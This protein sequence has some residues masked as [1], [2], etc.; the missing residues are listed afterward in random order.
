M[1]IFTIM[2][3]LC[4]T[5]IS[6]LCFQSVTAQFIRPSYDSL[7]INNVKAGINAE[8]S[9]F[10]D[11]I[12]NHKFEVPKGSGKSTIFAANLW[13]GA[14][15]ATGHQH[16]AAQ[17]YKQ[18]GTDYGSGPVSNSQV[19]DSTY[20]AQWNKL[21]KI[22]KAEVDAHIQNWSNWNYLMPASIVNYPAN[23]D[24]SKGQAAKLAPYQD[25]NQNNI[26]DPEN[27]DYPLIKGDQALLFLFN[28]DIYPHSETNS[29]WTPIK[30]EIL[31]MMYGFNAPNDSVLNN[32]VFLSYR[33]SNRS[34]KN[35]TDFKAGFWVDFSLG[36]GCYDDQVGSDSTNSYFYAYDE[37]GSLAY[38]NNAPVQSIVFL[39]H[40][41]NS[42]IAYNNDWSYSGNPNNGKDYVN[43]LDAIWKDEQP[44]VN[45]GF[46]GMSITTPGTPTKFMYTGNPC[47]ST[48]WLDNTLVP[49]D[50]RGLGAVHIPSWNSGETIEFEIALVYS[51]AASN[52]ESVCKAKDDI[53][54]LQGRYANGSLATTYPTENIQIEGLNVSPNP[55][56]YLLTISFDDEKLHNLELYNPLGQ[57]V[58][59]NNGVFKELKLDV[60]QFLKGIYILREG[61]KQ[62]K[63][64][65]K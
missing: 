29:S 7:E 47:D 27:G 56:E 26:Y 39:S 8:G 5:L 65:V 42:F 46:N 23:G 33:I 31:G 63:I 1:Q 18:K 30:A 17:T 35:Y 62:Q 20:N 50:I 34:S 52:L 55:V 40:K 13:L 10:W 22:S 19:Y 58:W 4:L 14:L 41:M 54:Y 28:D 57:K 61:N 60:R 45:N 2:K 24:I 11:L 21:W 59:A 32:T 9:L 37:N 51:R 64:W 44:L 12:S 38:G 48:G 25:V 49:E 3:N 16:C 6:I 15:D 53:S 43:Y 36:D